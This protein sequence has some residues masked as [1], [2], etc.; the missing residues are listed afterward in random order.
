MVLCSTK[1]E[2]DET[3]QLTQHAD[4]AL[5]QLLAAL[6]RGGYDFVAITPATHA[7]VV[8]R[9]DKVQARD[10]RDIFGWSLPFAPDVLPPEMLR[11]LER[12]GALVP[13]GTRLKSAIRVGR[14]Y[15]KLIL[16]SAYPSKDED[17]V[18]FSPDTYR[19]AEFIRAELPRMNGVQRLVD[20]GAGPGTGAIMAAAL[21]PGARLTLADINPLALRLAAINA[22]YAGLEVE[23]VDGG[24]EAVRGPF[25]AAI[26]NP[27]FMIDAEERTYRDGGDMHGGRLSLD[28]AVQAMERLSPGGRLLLYTGAAI[29]SGRDELKE[30]LEEA[31]GAGGHGIRYRELDPDIYGEELEGAA[32]RD[33]ERIAA[34]GAIVEKSPS[35]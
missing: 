15:G 11:L 10:L 5:F 3:L 18:F 30:R 12:A 8:A 28:W 1:A 20:I 26:A 16:H 4:E 23:L 34:I 7:R 25:D 31:A 35:R 2:E 33:V 19:F 9:P 6:E 13:Q 21:L 27:P 22:R 32:Y 17:S 24:L 29:V 14:I